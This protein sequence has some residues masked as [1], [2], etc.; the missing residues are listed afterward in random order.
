MFLIS[1]MSSDH[2][3]L[4]MSK[5]E[6]TR[7]LGLFI[8]P[9]CLQHRYI[10]HANSSHIFERPERLRAVLLGVAAAVARLELAQADF[11]KACDQN[12]A[13][14]ASI[15]TQGRGAITA[16]DLSIAPPDDLSSM[17]SSLSITSSAFTPPAHLNI[18]PP[19]TPTLAPGQVLLHH[20]ALQLAHS[21]PPGAPFPDSFSATSPYL[22]DLFKWASEAVERIK[23]TGN[24]IPQGL[25]QSDLYLGPGSILAI[26]GAVSCRLVI[27]HM[28]LISRRQIQ[29]LCQAIDGVCET[30]YA[31][32]AGTS[33]PPLPHLPSISQTIPAQPSAYLDA[34]PESSSSTSFTKAFCAI[35]P[36]GHHCGQ[37]IP[38]G[39]CY[40]N[41]VVVG[42]MHGTVHTP[43]Q[44]VE[45]IQRPAYLQ[46]RHQSGGDHRLRF[47][48]WCDIALHSKHLL[49]MYLQGMEHKR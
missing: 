23:E 32:K 28:L 1:L 25:N 20:P 22:K 41:N 11:K 2:L 49:T 18:V 5:A 14:Q 10:R 37:D 24:E 48:S 33:T 12:D 19:L 34:T 17:L 45:L 8:Q 47:T 26:E 3:A 43:S 29:T 7:P 40:V 46:P 35:R 15:G 42:A 21:P 4:K 44:K 39:F 13:S 38:S 6:S 9:A 16:N 31:V 36:P 30:V 27:R